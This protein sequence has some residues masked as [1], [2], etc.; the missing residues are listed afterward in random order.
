[1]RVPKPSSWVGISS[2]ARL[3]RLTV[4]TS[5]EAELSRAD[6]ETADIREQH[7]ELSSGEDLDAALG[8]LFAWVCGTDCGMAGRPGC[9]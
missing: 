5:G 1:M 3:A 9:R 6:V 8:S 4:W 2:A 7:V